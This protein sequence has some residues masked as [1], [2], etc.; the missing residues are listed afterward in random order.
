MN[1]IHRTPTLTAALVFAWSLTA[2]SP[3]FAQ[4]SMSDIRRQV[5]ALRA[6]VQQLRG[7]VNALKSA[8]AGP[9]VTQPSDAPTQPT[10]EMLQTQVAELAQVKVESTSRLPVKLFGSV[11]TGVFTNSSNTNWLDMPNI[12]LATPRDDPAGTMS[13]SL[14]QTRLGFSANG[15]TIGSARTNA[16]MAMDFYGGIPGFQTGQVM[17][18]PRLLVAFVRIES[19]RTA[20]EVGQDQMILAPRDPTS[21]AAFAF[22][23]LFRSGN[24]YLR[25]PQVRIERS[26]T[27]HLRATGGIVAPIAGDLTG[28][29]YL[30]VPPA[31]GGE[32]SR[33]PGAQARLAYTNGESDAATRLDVGISGHLGWK[34]RVDDLRKS[35]ATAVDFAARRGLVGVAGELFVGDNTGAFGGALGL[36]AKSGGG[37]A[38][39]ELFPSDRVSLTAGGGIDNV[40]DARRFTL[41]RRRNESAYANVIFSFTPEVQASFE[42][43]WL[44]TLVGNVERPNHHFDW[45]LVHKF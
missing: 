32:R 2:P 39:L 43:H 17:G 24:L 8:G 38:E 34:R 20:I 4:D 5:E 9:D 44:S 7:Q 35:W 29:D 13:A 40:T 28:N 19:E 33:R 16:V 22:P 37:W 15:P 26:L 27:T 12:V 41:P 23:A 30:F 36:D 25:V 1:L 14:R 6:E 11:H 10:L 42:Y 3:G 45:V 18:L 31:L 21:L